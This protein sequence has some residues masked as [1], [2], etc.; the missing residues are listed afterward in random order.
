MLTKE[1]RL[2]KNN[3]FKSVFEN[4]K[5]VSN[6][7]FF[8]KFKKNN[9]GINRFG[10][11]IGTKITKKAVL[12]NKIKRRLTEIIKKKLDEIESGLDIILIAKPKVINKNYSEIK[13]SIDDLFKKIKQMIEM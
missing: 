13:Q 4:G 12:R 1:N 7:L 9:L 6:E 10:F 8:L 11:V 3:D 2:R 5:S